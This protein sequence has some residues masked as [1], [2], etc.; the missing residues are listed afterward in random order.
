LTGAEALARALV[1]SDEDIIDM[2]DP[3]EGIGQSFYDDA[4]TRVQRMLDTLTVLGYAL[5]PKSD[6]VEI[7]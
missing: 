5:V 4:A 3:D 6:V 1:E 2:T 7:L